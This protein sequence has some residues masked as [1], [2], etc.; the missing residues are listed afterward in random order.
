M[1]ENKKSFILYVDQLPM[2]DTLTD[3]QAGKLIK[4][5][6]KYVNDENPILDDQLLNIAFLPIK[7]QLK[8]DLVKWE[9]KQEQRKEA[10]R[11]SAEIRA[12][13]SNEY[14]RPLT[15]VN[16]TQH[17]STVN[18]NVN[19]NG[20]VTVNGNGIIKRKKKEFT[21]PSIDEVKVYFSENGYTIDSATKAFNFYNTASWVD[22]RGQKVQNWK[23]K[24]I[25]VWFKDENKLSN[26]SKL[27]SLPSRFHQ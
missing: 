4:H 21:P 25:S 6:Y 24:M 13:K 27:V 7:Q 9:Q 19:V 2:V 26:A 18:G 10:G 16:E 14:Q 22:S 20:N 8:R 11:R 17:P 5:I 1:A 23:Q 12:T 15:T 3:E